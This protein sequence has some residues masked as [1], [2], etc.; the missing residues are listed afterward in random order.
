MHCRH[1]AVTA[2]GLLLPCCRAHMCGQ[3]HHTNAS[4]CTGS[5]AVT[6]LPHQPRAAAAAD[7]QPSRGT[8]ACFTRCAACQAGDAQHRGGAHA[9]GQPAQAGAG[10]RGRADQRCQ[11]AAG[12]APAPA[13]P[14]TP[15]AP[16]QYA[17]LAL[18]AR[19]PRSAVSAVRDAWCAPSQGESLRQSR[20]A[21]HAGLR[22]PR[23]ARGRAGPAGRPAAPR[24]GRALRRGA[25]RQGRRSGCARTAG[26]RPRSRQH[27]HPLCTA[28]MAPGSS[29]GKRGAARTG[30]H[31]MPLG[32]GLPSGSNARRARCERPH[33]ERLEKRARGRRPQGCSGAPRSERSERAHLTR[34][35]RA[36]RAGQPDGN[37]RAEPRG[38]RGD[39]ARG[40]AHRRRRAASRLQ[41][42]RARAPAGPVRAGQVAA[43][44]ARRTEPKD[45]ASGSQVGGVQ[46]MHGA[47]R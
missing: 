38:H 45:R 43:A 42:R 12:A 31:G 30:A 40:R 21:L 5:G 16:T 25:R 32:G 7:G 41:R 17:A 33:A 22:A 11:P 46:H 34:P 47:H 44:H 19:L 10:A 15:P 20:T 37:A 8:A 29:V 23:R 6:A 14:A 2:F 4:G 13:P 39:G 9:G 18:A 24:R 26:G 27:A 35:Q 36:R 28:R 1:A 3:A